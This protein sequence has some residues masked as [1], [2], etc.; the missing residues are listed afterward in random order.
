LIR[1]SGQRA[2]ANPVPV[3]TVI[4]ER[5]IFSCDP[6]LDQAVDAAIK[7]F[8][9]HHVPI[10]SLEDNNSKM[11]RE[12]SFGLSLLLCLPTVIISLV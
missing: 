4:E 11:Q 2:L 8:I 6:F 12:E 9:D 3:C 1:C 10:N 5:D 7:S